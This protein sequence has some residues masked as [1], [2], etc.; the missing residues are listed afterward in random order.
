MKLG[1]FDIGTIPGA[2]SF[3]PSN[4]AFNLIAQAATPAGPTSVPN[5]NS[6]AGA[7]ISASRFENET[8]SSAGQSA[9]AKAFGFDPGKADGKT[10][11]NAFTFGDV[12]QHPLYIAGPSVARSETSNKGLQ[13]TFYSQ[14][15][16]ETAAVEM[17]YGNKPDG[18]A[19]AKEVIMA[20]EVAHKLVAAHPQLRGKIN[21]KDNE[22]IGNAA[23]LATDSNFAVR[24]LMNAKQAERQPNYSGVKQTTEKAFNAMDQQLNMKGS[25]ADVMKRFDS[26]VGGAETSYN[27]ANLRAFAKKEGVSPDA[28]MSALKTE[29]TR[30]F[31]DASQSIIKKALSEP[32]YPAGLK[33][34]R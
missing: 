30:A 20:Q 26:F 19:K 12:D 9:I 25:G 6:Y 2:G 3:V 8:L 7:G 32:D 5:G 14:K 34:Q 10:L 24:N 1:G 17:G 28:F 27:E 11:P 23:S 21:I 33:V 29:T 15:K 22:I 18:I 4:L 13:E 31:T 16:L